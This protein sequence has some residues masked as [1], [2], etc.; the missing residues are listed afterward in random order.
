LLSYSVV[1]SIKDSS[2]YKTFK[3]VFSGQIVLGE[4]VVKECLGM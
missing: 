2:I 1:E 3:S 4:Q